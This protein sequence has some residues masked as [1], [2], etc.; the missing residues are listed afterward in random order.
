MPQRAQ[1]NRERNR[2]GSCHQAIDAEGLEAPGN[3]AMQTAINRSVAAEN[4][5]RF[6]CWC[7]PPLNPVSSGVT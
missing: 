2:D 6:H 5:G 1:A 7:I 4:V 3:G